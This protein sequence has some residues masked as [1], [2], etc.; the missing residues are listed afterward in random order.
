[1]AEY[2][3]NSRIDMTWNSRPTLIYWQSYCRATDIDTS[4]SVERAKPAVEEM[5]RRDAILQC[6]PKN[7]AYSDGYWSDKL[8]VQGS[9]LGR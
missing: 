4:N 1:M 9:Q 8:Q 3:N 7:L 6:E 5:S 2:N